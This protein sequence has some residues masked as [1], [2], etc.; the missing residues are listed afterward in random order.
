MNMKAKILSLVATAIFLSGCGGFVKSKVAVF[1]RLPENPT[2]TNYAFVPLKGQENNLEYMTY[3]DLIRKQLSKYQYREVTPQETPDVII[4]FKYG[5]DNGKEKLGSVPIF[6]RTGVSSSTT[7][8]TFNTYG[9]S[10]TYSGTTFYTPSYGIIGSSAVSRTVYSRALWL[11]IVDAKSVGTEKLNVL[12]E[13]SVKSA[14]RSS[15]LS[16]VMPAMIKALFKKFPGKNGETWTETNT[17]K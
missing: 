2:P 15:Q 14:G 17:V 13:G 3:Q 11:Y 6:G 1:Q 5:I 12:Y 7:Y 10:G 9:N 4:A 16:E 8:G